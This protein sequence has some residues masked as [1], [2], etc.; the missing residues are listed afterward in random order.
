MQERLLQPL[1]EERAV[2]QP[3]ERIVQRA[4]L[5]LLLEGPPLDEGRAQVP[6]DPAEARD[7]EKEQHDAAGGDDRDV[8]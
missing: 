4:M 7:D 2:R 8:E 5:E 6:D 1:V 3:G